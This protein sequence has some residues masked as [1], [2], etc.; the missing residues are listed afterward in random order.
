MWQ[1]NEEIGK[2]PLYE[3]KNWTKKMAQKKITNL[4]SSRKTKLPFFRNYRWTVKS[5]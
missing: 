2:F 1:I 5:K 3:Q 4:K